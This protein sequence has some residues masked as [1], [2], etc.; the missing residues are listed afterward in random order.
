MEG[1]EVGEGSRLQGGRGGELACTTGPCA[2]RGRARSR[3][4]ASRA[5]RSA[6]CCR[7]RGEVLQGGGRGRGC[8]RRGEERGEGRL[9]REWESKKWRTSWATIEGGG[10]TGE[11]DLAGA[12]KKKRRL[13]T[14]HWS[15]RWTEGTGTKLSTR[16]TQRY[17]RIPPTTHELN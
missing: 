5:G 6:S 16:R 3:H 9:L 10:L 11:E 12:K 1:K 4:R 14:N 17:P 2:A 7:R 15:D 8:H 13:A